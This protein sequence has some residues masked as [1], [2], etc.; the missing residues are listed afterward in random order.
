M[1]YAFVFSILAI[2][3]SGEALA[4]Q[5]DTTIL[6]PA[7]DGKGAQ[8]L[9]LE[10][11]EIQFVLDGAEGKIPADCPA[12]AYWALSAARIVNCGNG[13]IYELRKTT[14]VGILGAFALIPTSDSFLEPPTELGSMDEPEANPRD[15]VKEISSSLP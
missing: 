3:L 10:T 2:G 8:T 6:I 14:N 9:N 7:K 11:R 13:T 12:N 15:S 1:R 4:D 5:W